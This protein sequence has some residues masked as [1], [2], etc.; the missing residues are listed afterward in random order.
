MNCL[1]WQ[2]YAV[3]IPQFYDPDIFLYAQRHIWGKLGRGLP[4]RG[5]ILCMSR[6]IKV[7]IN[8]RV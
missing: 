4:Q 6:T 7:T 1:L 3:V 2:I 5:W 8:H